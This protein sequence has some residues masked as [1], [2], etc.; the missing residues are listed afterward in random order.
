MEIQRTKVPDGA[1]QMRNKY[2][3]KS[4][5]IGD[6]VFVPD[7]KTADKIQKAARSYGRYHGIPFKMSRTHYDEKI[8]MV[9]VE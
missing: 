2:P 4:I 1:C 6:W 3:F 9:R 7:E 5:G 8:Y